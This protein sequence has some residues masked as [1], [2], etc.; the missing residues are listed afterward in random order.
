MTIDRVRSAVRIALVAVGVLGSLTLMSLAVRALLWWPVGLAALL[1]FGLGV[2]A[3][4]RLAR[5]LPRRIVLEVDFE[6]P[7]V[8]HVPADPLGRLIASDGLVLRDL[9]DALRRGAGDRRVTGLV[10]RV[11]PAAPG[12]A[13][14]QEIRAAV[15]EFRAAGKSAVAIAETFGED[16]NALA[17]FYLATAFEEIHLLPAGDLMT[18]GLHK[19]LPFLRRLLD[20]IGVVPDFG[21][22][23]EFKSA[24]DMLTEE[25]MS[26]SQ[27]EAETALLEARFDQV[28]AGIATARNLDPEAVRAL[29]DRSPLQAAEALEAG[30]V[31]RLSYRDEVYEPAKEGA[32]LLSVATYLKRAGRPDRRGDRVAL[33]YGVGPV[34]R[35]SRPLNAISPGFTLSSD[36]VAAAF[37]AAVEDR[38]VKAV[39]FRVDSPG[40]SAIASEVIWREVGRARAAGKPVV[41]SM[42]NVAASGGYYVAAGADKIVAQ[43]ATVTGSIG[44]IS[45]KLVHAD[46]MAKMGIG[47]DEVHAGAHAGMWS[48]DRPFTDSE[49][50]RFEAGLDAVYETFKSRVADGRGMA[51]DQVEEV[52]RGRVWDGAAAHRLGLVDEL[53]GLVTAVDLAK[54]AAHL[55][56]AQLVVFPR[57]RW[58]A[59]MRRRAA[60]T[61]ALAPLARLLAGAAGGAALKAAA[62]PTLPLLY[63]G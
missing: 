36:E 1:A 33:I 12:L 40:G 16:R 32:K 63:D 51:P 34:L 35:K 58:R 13:Q 27:R 11:G 28:V 9:V 26:P 61:D 48:P 37:R 44:V 60:T 25:R 52:A 17:G 29:V 54:Q 14:V 4:R 53:G 20:M 42:G 19:R 15:A 8:E 39:V 50:E 38:K 30:L 62:E 5:H 55:D 45:G 57:R 21:R 10:A 43:P 41:V 3:A 47:F 18:V 2:L 46:A 23:R 59:A 22:R 56:Q 31:D 24:A 6:R 7:V 49:R